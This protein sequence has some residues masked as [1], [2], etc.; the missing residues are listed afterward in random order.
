ML[1]GYQLGDQDSAGEMLGLQWLDAG[2][3]IVIDHPAEGRARATP[4]TSVSTTED[5]LRWRT[6]VAS[7]G[8]DDDCFAEQLAV[9]RVLVDGRQFLQRPAVGDVQLEYA[10]V[11]AG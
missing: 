11:D 2:P 6:G 4:Y 10:V 3:E 7:A 9:A 8:D 1:R 5:G